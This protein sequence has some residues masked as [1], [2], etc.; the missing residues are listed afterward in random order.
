MTLEMRVAEIAAATGGEVISG[1]PELV[2]RGVGTDSREIPQGAL[3]VALV[4]ARDGHTF[5]PSALQRGAV[6]VLAQRP[7]TEA[8]RGETANLPV[9]LVQ[10]TLTALG[11]LASAW[12][13]RH[14]SHCKV[15]GITGSSG[16]TTGK[17]ML[18]AILQQVAPTLKT[19]GN[20]NNLIGLPLTLF[21]LEPK[22][23]YAVLEM[24]M[25][26]FG[27]IARMTEIAR[28]DIGWITLVAPA[29]LEGVGSLDGVAKAKGEL[30]LG[31]GGHD[32]AIVNADDPKIMEK[33]AS[34]AC[35]KV[36][37]ST[38]ADAASR[39][40]QEARFVTLLQATPLG[41]EGFSVSV[42]SFGHGRLS[43]RL[44]LVGRHQIANA[45]GAIAAAAVLG[46]PVQAIIAGLEQLQPEGRRLRVIHTDAG[47]HLIDDCYNSNPASKKA[48][49]QT[50][51]DLAQDAPSIAILG[52]MLELGEA[53]SE[54]HAMIGELVAKHAIS[55]FFAFGPRAK[56]M[57]KSALAHGMPAGKV[58]AFEEASFEA[59]W[60]ALRPLLVQGA[61]V[62]VKGS[63]GM[64]LERI[65]QR[66]ETYNPMRNTP[67]LPLYS[68]ET[69]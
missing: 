58:H 36:Y 49:L 48:A 28:P 46:A 15:V 8:E 37:Y 16:K 19:K 59:M 41:E 11:D 12:L 34:L 47:V 30:F 61:R 13:S 38:D 64:R 24:G 65:S 27:E 60:D 52:D 69:E 25:N 62:L 29:H 6:A 43:F 54:M 31:L 1:N 40:P 57:A 14:R 2:V 51:V 42:H 5:V 22:H 39:L 55:A 68:E 45:L 4:A 56:G 67:I 44:P 18:G 9:I 17:E 3:F 26:A 21:G 33:S 32:T 10:D 35:A 63:R 23:R 66:I 20:L 50:L 7:L 53:E